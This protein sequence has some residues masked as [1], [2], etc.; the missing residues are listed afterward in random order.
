MGSYEF[1]VLAEIVK[2]EA[3][4]Q[5][6][7]EG[8]LKGWRQVAEETRGKVPADMGSQKRFLRARIDLLQRDADY[9]KK[10]YRHA[11]FA[12]KEP[13]K[14]E[15]AMNVALEFWAALFAPTMNKWRSASVDW[16]DA[17][18]RYLTEKFFAEGN[19]D[20]ET[21]DGRKGRWTRTVSKDLWNQTHVFAAKTLQDESL[22][23]WSEDQA[24]PAVVDEFV[25]WCRAKGVVPAG[26]EH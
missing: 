11:F 3:F 21:R 20:D 23:F 25:V 9:F 22:S 24:W 19:G 12:G 14:R 26:S 1:F 6:T 13:G 7:R 4:G 18:E 10:V 8:F 16:L 5:I 17:W 15:M 2:V